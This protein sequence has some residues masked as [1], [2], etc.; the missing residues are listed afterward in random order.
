MKV[1]LLLTFLLFMHY[2]PFAHPT[3][4]AAQ[5]AAPVAKQVDLA[6]LR[7][8][9]VQALDNAALTRDVLK[10]LEALNDKTPLLL[11]YE[12]AFESLVAK[13]HWNPYQKVANL[14]SSMQKLEQAILKSPAH[15][16]IRFLRF[17]IQH[18]LPNFLNDEQM[19]A[20]DKAAILANFD[21]RESQQLGEQV[22]KTIAQFLK[23]SGRC[24]EQELQSVQSALLASAK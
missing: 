5:A 13:H 7:L 11:A 20:A 19:L 22:L 24:S 16:E 23:E 18:H 21:T 17:S 3:R 6:E 4:T 12:G 14:K 2:K 1:S 10:Q 8:Q 9:Y 15:V